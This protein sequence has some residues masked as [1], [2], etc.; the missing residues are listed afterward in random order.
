MLAN[1]GTWPDLAAASTTLV[2]CEQVWP[3]GQGQ[4]RSD[5]GG[6]TWAVHLLVCSDLLGARCR[7][8][9]GPQL[10]L[11]LLSGTHPLGPFL[12]LNQQPCICPQ[13]S[14]TNHLY[15]PPSTCPKATSSRKPAQIPNGL[16]LLSPRLWFSRPFSG[17]CLGRFHPTEAEL[18]QKVGEDREKAVVWKPEDSSLQKLNVLTP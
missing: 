18:V 4:R 13:S 14:P 7:P 12:P 3:L 1:L 2:F 15:V 11:D 9:P 6:R 8:G 16:C 10:W 5:H 17:S